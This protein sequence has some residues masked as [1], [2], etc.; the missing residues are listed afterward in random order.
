V[1]I[2]ISCDT[3]CQEEDFLAFLGTISRKYRCVPVHRYLYIR[4]MS[5]LVC[6]CVCV[7]ACRYMH[8]LVQKPSVAQ[9]NMK[10]DFISF[11]ATI[12]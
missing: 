11:L 9:R 7:C 12:S 1:V 4:L 6:V 10:D 8:C 2:E 5:I 3:K